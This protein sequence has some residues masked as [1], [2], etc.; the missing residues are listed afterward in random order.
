MGAGQAAGGSCSQPCQLKAAGARRQA[1][2]PASLSR[3]HPALLDTTRHCR[4]SR[5]DSNRMGSWRAQVVAR[6]QTERPLHCPG[7]IRSLSLMYMAAATWATCALATCA[8]ECAL[9]SVRVVSATAPVG[10]GYTCPLC[11][12]RVQRLACSAGCSHSASHTCVHVCPLPDLKQAP[13]VDGT[14]LLSASTP[15][16]L[17][18]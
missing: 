1:M 9:W 11:P 12:R 10:S 2:Q 4:P 13:E 15:S 18:H 16:G 8:I 7:R 3:P 5:P 14:A 6:V 17:R